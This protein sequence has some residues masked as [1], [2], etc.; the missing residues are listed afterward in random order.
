MHRPC[1]RIYCRAETTFY[2]CRR[3]SW[4]TSIGRPS[5]QSAGQVV[6]LQG[7]GGIGKSVLAAAL[8]HTIA[9]RRAFAD[10]IVWLSA[11]P[12]A[13]DL[14]RLGNMRRVGDALGD[15]PQHY[16]EEPTAKLHL[17]TVLAAKVCLII[18]DDV[19]SMDQVEAFRDALGPRCRLLAHH[20]RCRAGDC[21]RGSSARGRYLG[22]RPGACAP[23][24]MVWRRSC[25]ATPGGASDS[26]AVWE[27]ALRVVALRRPPSR[28]CEPLGE[29][30]APSRTC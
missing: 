14:T 15:D 4:P 29:P 10:G 20:S 25:L 8:A 26:E 6:A 23:F 9:A 2:G 27:P 13:T 22:G 17:A 1:H 11:G 19:W 28:Q 5:S 7:M 24:R 30:A 18:L 3:A 12:E 16:V 21:P